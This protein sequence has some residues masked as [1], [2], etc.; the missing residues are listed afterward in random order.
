MTQHIRVGARKRS[1]EK[2]EQVAQSSLAGG[3]EYSPHSG[4]ISGL[5]DIAE[6][7]SPAQRAPAAW[8]PQTQPVS[9]PRHHVADTELTVSPVALGT[10]VFGWT[11]GADAASEVLGL[12]RELGGNFIDNAES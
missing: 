8:A 2:Q 1:D 11:L 12:Y 3:L 9:A 6:L 5:A 7:G 10:S 4:A